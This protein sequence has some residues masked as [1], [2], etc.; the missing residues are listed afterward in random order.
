LA[1][2]IISKQGLSAQ[3]QWDFIIVIVLIYRDFGGMNAPHY[4]N[5]TFSGDSNYQDDMNYRYHVNS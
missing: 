2:S 4:T 3:E 1:A 5:T